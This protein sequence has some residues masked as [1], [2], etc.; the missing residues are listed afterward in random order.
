VA[1]TAD[2][3]KWIQAQLSA[4][5]LVDSKAHGFGYYLAHGEKT[6]AD[7]LAQAKAN[8]TTLSTVKATLDSLD[9]SQVPAEVAAKIEHLKL[10]V[11]VE[12]TP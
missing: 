3:K 11:T 9:L 4:T 8:G 12:E 2:D 7:I 10:V 1:L 5:S 6:L